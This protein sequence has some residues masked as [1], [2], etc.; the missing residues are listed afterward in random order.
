M[1][2]SEQA[3]LTIALLHWYQSNHRRS[4][5]KAY[6]KAIYSLKALVQ[7]LNRKLP[8]SDGQVMKLVDALENDVNTRWQ[9]MP[10]IIKQVRYYLQDH[11]PSLEL[12]VKVKEMCDRLDNGYKDERKYGAQIPGLIASQTKTLPFVREKHGLIKHG[13]S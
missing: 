8:L 5:H 10:G 13:S 4:S 7:L 6:E 1:N 11:Q 2:R 3:E 12:L 9:W